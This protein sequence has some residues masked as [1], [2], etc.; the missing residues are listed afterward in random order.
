MLDDGEPQP[1][2]ALVAAGGDVH[3]VEPLGQTRQVLGRDPHAP[4]DHRYRD[5]RALGVRALQPLQR[6]RDHLALGAVF[7]GVLDQVLEQLDQL[8]ALT[9]HR[10]PAQIA[11]EPQLELGL[12]GQRLHQIDDV[13]HG[14]AH[15]D[16]LVGRQMRLHLDPAERQQIV[17]QPRHAAGLLGHDVEKAFLGF[18]VLAGGPL[19]G[20]DEADQRGERGAQLV[21]RIGDE[22]L[23]HPVGALLLGE[24]AHARQ[25]QPGRVGRASGG[26]EGRQGGVDPPF[27]RHSLQIA[28]SDRRLGLADVADGV[29]EIG[30]AD[31][32]RDVAAAAQSPILARRPGIVGDDRAARGKQ[33]RGIGDRL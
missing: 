18:G 10:H 3:P 21:A 26:R 31:H 11:L 16:D 17:D 1:G 2:A 29:E 19:Q 24:I 14:L 12:A 32:H 20:L 33:D 7:D 15:I 6:D 13:A 8:V 4:V 9:P 23:A 22:V 27:D 25:H 28:H 5:P 30:V